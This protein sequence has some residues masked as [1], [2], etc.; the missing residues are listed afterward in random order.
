MNDVDGKYYPLPSALEALGEAIERAWGE[1]DGWLAGVLGVSAFFGLVL[2]L[3][4]LWVWAL[5]WSCS[6]LPSS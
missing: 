3:P 4:A 2:G 6:N 5:I 1:G